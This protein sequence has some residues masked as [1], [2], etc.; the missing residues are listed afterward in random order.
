MRCI[1]YKYKLYRWQKAKDE[2]M[3]RYDK[4]IAEAEKA[5]NIVEVEKLKHE[6]YIMSVDVWDEDIFILKTDYLTE[7]ANKLII[8]IEFSKDS[9]EWREGNRTGRWFLTKKGV[10][11]LR[12]KIRKERKERLELFSIV[13]TLIIGILGA[14]IGLISI[15]KA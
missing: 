14:L 13:A 6:Q 1:K 3:E 4:Q 9:E 7:Q 15:I 12:S 2:E 10:D 5:G 8:P 11:N